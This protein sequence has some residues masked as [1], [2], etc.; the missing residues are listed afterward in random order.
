MQV[1]HHRDAFDDLLAGE[2]QHQ[3]QHAVRRRMLRSQI[4][5][6]LL[7]LEAF[8]LDDR[9]LDAGAFADLAKL[10]VG[11]AQRYPPFAI[12]SRSRSTPSVSASGRGGQPGTYTSTGTTVSTPWSVE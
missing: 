7:G 9:K 6:Q 8:V 4:Q 11:G 12:F 10:G 3:T 5:D 1:S 2:A